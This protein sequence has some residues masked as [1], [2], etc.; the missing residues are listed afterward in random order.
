M[1]CADIALSDIL[2]KHR[3]AHAADSTEVPVQ[4]LSNGSVPRKSRACNACAKAREKCT[5][6]LPCMRCSRRFLDCVYPGSQQQDSFDHHSFGE[7]TSTSKSPH[8]E[9]VSVADLVSSGA[10]QENLQDINDNGHN[11]TALMF[12]Q[13]HSQPDKASDSSTR[14]Y[15]T[16]GQTAP[17]TPISGSPTSDNQLSSILAP[18]HSGSALWP[19]RNDGLQSGAEAFGQPINW[20]PFDETIDLNL[21]PTLDGTVLLSPFDD[22]QWLSINSST[23]ANGLLEGQSWNLDIPPLAHI[24]DK[25][26]NGASRNASIADISSAKGSFFSSYKRGDLYATSSN[27]ARNACSTRA[28]RDDQDSE[29]SEEQ[30]TDLPGLQARILNHVGI[31]YSESKEPSSAVRSMWSFTLSLINSQSHK[32]LLEYRDHKALKPNGWDEWVEAESWRRLYFTGRVLNS[33]MAYHFNFDIDQSGGAAADFALPQEKLWQAQTRHDWFG[34]ITKTERNPSLSEATNELFQAKSVRPNLGEFS[35]CIILHEVYNEIAKVTTYHSRQLASW[36]PTSESRSVFPV[37][38][39]ES[40]NLRVRKLTV[41]GHSVQHSNAVSDWRNAALDGVDVLHWAANAKIASLSGAEHPMVLHLHYSR[42]VLLVP[43]VALIAIGE[44]VLPMLN[45]NEAG[46]RRSHSQ[47]AIQAA[48][49]IIR[50]WTQRDGSKARLAVIHGGCVFWHI[51]RYS[52]AAF[53][54]PLSIFYATLALWAYGFYTPRKKSSVGYGPTSPP[55]RIPSHNGIVS[56]GEELDCDSPESSAQPP[57]RQHAHSRDGDL[58]FIRLDRPNDDE[59]VQLFV[60]SSQTS[61]MSALV[62]GVGDICGPEGPALVLKEG[63]AM[64]GAIPQ[65]WIQGSHYMDILLALEVAT[66][67]RL[68]RG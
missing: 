22:A 28:K 6:E 39:S 59:M 1:Y 21:G 13:T 30:M 65:T 14:R 44:S 3:S 41:L 26:S 11:L 43:R 17:W 25:I 8:A 58:T 20:L 63:R 46:F 35:H 64:L 31:F 50:E 10:L 15:T 7:I 56:G 18:G 47:K 38:S 67:N 16:A 60:S 52:R 19:F 5:K 61:R 9:N 36:T 12:D 51:R 54:E 4:P 29:R 62:S 23:I 33:M 34:L 42:I 57:L 48:E 2:S 49:N 27:G 66:R 53:Y 24:D 37:S 32:H 68:S 40:L 45:D 55:G